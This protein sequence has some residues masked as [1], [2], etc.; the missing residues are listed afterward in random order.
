MTQKAD[1]SQKGPKLFTL[2]DEEQM[3]R[4]THRNYNL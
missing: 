3:D 4:I 1:Q 2:G